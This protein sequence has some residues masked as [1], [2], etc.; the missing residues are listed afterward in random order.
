ILN[1]EDY[2]I[3]LKLDSLYETKKL[4]GNE[5]INKIEIIEDG[6]SIRAMRECHIS[7]INY[8]VGVVVVESDFN[9][10]I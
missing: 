7:S 10:G 2:V 3:T 9:F 5:K 8:D 1:D 6:I 4:K